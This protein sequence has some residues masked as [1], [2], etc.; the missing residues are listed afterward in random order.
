MS[1]VSEVLAEKLGFPEGQVEQTLDALRFHVCESLQR[2]NAVRLTDFVVFDY[3]DRKERVRRNPRTGEKVIATAGRFPKARFSPAFKKA[4]R[5]TVLQT[6]IPNLIPSPLDTRSGSEVTHTPPPLPIV[7]P[8]LPE[9]QFFLPTGEQKG[10]S[11]ILKTV[12][13]QTLIWHPDFGQAWKRA[14][15]VFPHL[16]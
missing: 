16:P 4:I 7:P 15:E 10:E 14:G 1:K 11:E 13:A 2:G 9:R 12:T 3:N 5:S 6:S 8:P